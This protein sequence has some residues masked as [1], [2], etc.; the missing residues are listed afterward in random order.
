MYLNVTGVAVPAATVTSFVATFFQPPDDVLTCRVTV[1]SPAEPVVI[2]HHRTDHAGQVAAVG[3]EE[4]LTETMGLEAG[5]HDDRPDPRARDADLR[6]R[7]QHCRES[8]GQAHRGARR[9]R[10]RRDLGAEEEVRRRRVDELLIALDVATAGAEDAGDPVDEPDFVRARDQDDVVLAPWTTIKGLAVGQ[11]VKLRIA[12]APAPPSM[13]DTPA[14]VRFTHIDQI[15]VKAALVDQIFAKAA[16]AEEI[17]QATE[18][19]KEVLRQRHRLQADQPDDFN[20]RDM[21]ELLKALAPY[22]G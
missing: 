6:P 8:L 7:R 3:Q 4:Q 18:Q 15:T 9:I 2:A 14:P 1:R 20:I 13:A 5:Q 19:I 10:G 16:S 22:R 11:D 17:P 12:S 21:N